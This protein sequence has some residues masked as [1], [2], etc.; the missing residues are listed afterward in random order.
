MPKTKEKD[1]TTHF[2]DS[3]SETPIPEAETTIIE[4]KP[5]VKKKVGKCKNPR[6]S[7][8][9][10]DGD[11]FVTLFPDS[12]DTCEY[13]VGNGDWKK[14]SS[15]FPLQYEKATV[16]VEFKSVNPDKNDSDVIQVNLG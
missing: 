16:H 2:I 13:R 8:G 7:K 1:F 15:P 9:F 4:E 11:I 10:K 3:T 14:Y 12:G 6:F 5:V